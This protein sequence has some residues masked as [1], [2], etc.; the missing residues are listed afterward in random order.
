M[1]TGGDEVYVDELPKW[2]VARVRR[3]PPDVAGLVVPYSTPIACFGDQRTATVATLGINPSASEF[4]SRG[5]LLEGD[6]RRLETLASL[7][8]NRASELTDA[9]VG[10]LIKGCHDYFERNPYYWFDRL[11]P[12]LD[13]VGVAYPARSACHLDLVQWATVPMWSAIREDD[14]TLAERLLREDAPFLVEQL[15]WQRPGVGS[16]RLVLVNG[17]EAVNQCR[18]VGVP[19]EPLDPLLFDGRRWKFWHAVWEGVRLLGWHANLPSS[20]T[21]PALR[22]AVAQH[23]ARMLQQ[24]GWKETAMT[25]KGMFGGTEKPSDQPEVVAVAPAAARLIDDLRL[26]EARFDIEVRHGRVQLMAIGDDEPTVLLDVAGLSVALDPVAAQRLAAVA[27]VDDVGP[28]PGGRRWL[29]IPTEALAH[30]A[31]RGY[32]LVVLLRAL[33]RFDELDLDDAVAC[34]ELVEA[35]VE[36]E[37]YREFPKDMAEYWRRRKEVLLELLS[38]DLPELESP[39]DR[40]WRSPEQDRQHLMDLV[41]DAARDRLEGVSPMRAYI[42]APEVF[43]EIPKL[44]EHQE[45]FAR[46]TEQRDDTL[47]VFMLDLLERAYPGISSRHTSHRTL[48]E[49]GVEPF[50]PRDDMELAMDGDW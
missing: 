9:Q 48:L 41:G 3:E 10:R 28:G 35:F 16:W 12:V 17:R 30:G 46:I 31:T 15:R 32:L 34:D 43:L 7:G 37:R 39:A 49:H 36:S 25:P 24:L 47:H 40:P 1:I 13:V 42:E 22:E 20:R 44:H 45:A 29:H 27:P 38:A 19:W 5:R 33:A 26:H 21:P 18:D 4:S 8:A 6:E 11:S 50:P 2:M 14:P 23:A